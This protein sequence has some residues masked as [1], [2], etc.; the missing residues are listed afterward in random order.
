M[1]AMA[2]PTVRHHPLRRPLVQ[3]THQTHSSPCSVCHAVSAYATGIDAFCDTMEDVASVDVPSSCNA[4]GSN[5]RRHSTHGR[6]DRARSVSERMDDRVVTPPPAAG[7]LDSAPYTQPFRVYEAFATEAECAELIERYG[8]L[9]MQSRVVGANGE[10][11]LD[12]SA[13]TSQ[14]YYIPRADCPTIASIERKTVELLG[15]AL[16]Q[17]ENLQIVRY[18]QGQQYKYHYD[19]FAH[20]MQ[21][22]AEQRATT[23]L[24]YLNT[25]KTEEGEWRSHVP[26]A[27]V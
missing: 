8:N 14:S 13:R 22:L 11:V 12:S 1:T 5:T 4:G 26:V 25:M 10:S 7:G 2:Q 6:R 24:L 15:V 16:D 3:V 18:E 20:Q 17:I 27:V 19:Y 21:S 9:T 23:V